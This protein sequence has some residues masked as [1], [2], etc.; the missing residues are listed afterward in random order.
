MTLLYLDGKFRTNA[1]KT[2]PNIN[3]YVYDSVSIPDKYD[4][5]TTSYDTTGGSTETGYKWIVFR[6]DKTSSFVKSASKIG[7]GVAIYMMYQD[8]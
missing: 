1:D 8:Y 6:I 2:Y 5:G 4:K 3:N 7:G